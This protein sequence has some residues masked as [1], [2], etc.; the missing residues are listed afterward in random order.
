MDTT[1]NAAIS[2]VKAHGRKLNITANNVANV[3]TNGFKRDQALLR[4]GAAGDVRVHVRKDMTPAPPDPLAPDAPGIA[5]ALS[6][7]DLADEMPGLIPTTIGYKV[8]LKVIRAR[9]EM[10]GSLLDTLA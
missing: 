10:I 1:F 8:N 2:S 6:N 7:V 3:N 4:E 9:D 5:K